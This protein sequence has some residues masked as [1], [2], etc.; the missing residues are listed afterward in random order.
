[1]IYKN[2]R[3]V[4]VMGGGY[5]K[6]KDRIVLLLACAQATYCTYMYPPGIALYFCQCECDLCNTSIS[7]PFSQ[8]YSLVVSLVCSFLSHTRMEMMCLEVLK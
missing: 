7:G 1:M 8:C 3:S 2:H 4:T 5:I 6:K